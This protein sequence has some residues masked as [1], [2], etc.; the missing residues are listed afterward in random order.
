[1]KVIKAPNHNPNNKAIII[2]NP[3]CLFILT[4]NLS[5]ANEKHIVV[6]CPLVILNM[7]SIM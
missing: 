5:G 7:S 4:S 2:T 3:E 6:K 1:M